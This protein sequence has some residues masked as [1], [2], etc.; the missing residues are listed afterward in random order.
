[1]RR[2]LHRL[3]DLSVPLSLPTAAIRERLN[4]DRQFL[5][6][7][8]GWEMKVRLGVGEDDYLLEIDGGRVARFERGLD[9]FD[10]YAGS[11]AGTE[12]D[13]ELLL[14]E[15]PPPFYQDFI[16][17]WF[18]Q[19]FTLAGDLESLFAYMDA[20]RRMLEIMRQV[21]NGQEAVAG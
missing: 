2:R 15:V 13:W 1:M 18:R 14:R 19:G 5:R 6:A 4:G 8:R 3:R 21:R 12:D 16:G 7:A 20:L 11:L 10:S 17:A 9:F